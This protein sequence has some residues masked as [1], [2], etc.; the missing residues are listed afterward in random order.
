MPKK[1]LEVI[2]SLKQVSSDYQ[3]HIEKEKLKFLDN[4]VLTMLDY[5]IKTNKDLYKIT[6]DPSIKTYLEKLEKQRKKI[7]AHIKKRD[8]TLIKK[9]KLIENTIPDYKEY[10]ETLDEYKVIL[11]TN[12]QLNVLLDFNMNEI[13]IKL[14]E[15]S[16]IIK[17]MNEKINQITDGLSEDEMEKLRDYMNYFSGKEP[18]PKTPSPQEILSKRRD[19]HDS[20]FLTAL[21]KLFRVMPTG[22]KL[23]KSIHS[24]FMQ[25]PETKAILEEKKTFQLP[26]KGNSTIKKRNE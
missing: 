12:E 10:Q 2:N 8:K 23:S 3:K 25:H 9:G 14:N 13:F 4:E 7:D 24:Y 22:A 5:R 6:K 16:D 20:T 11:G 1:P 18:Y 21:V 17:T 19:V 15:K 26:H